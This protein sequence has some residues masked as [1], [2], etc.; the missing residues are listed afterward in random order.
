VR[1]QLLF[2]NDWRCK[3]EVD[4][5]KQAWLRG[6]M[7]ELKGAPWCRRRRSK[8]SSVLRAYPHPHFWI[9]HID[10]SAMPNPGRMAVGVVLTG[11]DGSVHQLA[12]ALPGSGCNNEAELRALQ[13]GLALAQAQ[14]AS[15]VRIYTDSHWLLE[16]LAAQALGWPQARA[17]VRLAHWIGAAQAQLRG[18]AEVQW[19]WIPRHHNTEA[20]ALA[21]QACLTHT[22]EMADTVHTA[23]VPCPAT[24]PTTA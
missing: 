18:W 8:V 3:A 4:C 10:G 16:Q 17:T 14:G 1:Y 24:L 19:R 15:G 6:M 21:R 5:A 22:A 9:L 12:Q 23:A 13:A 11:P 2:L 20:D 7:Q